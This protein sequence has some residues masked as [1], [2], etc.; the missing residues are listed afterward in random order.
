VD[1][2]SVIEG[3]RFALISKPALAEQIE[4]LL[5]NN[6]TIRIGSEYPITTSNNFGYAPEK[7]WTGKSEGMIDFYGPDNIQAVFGL[8][9]TGAEIERNSLIIIRDH[10]EAVQLVRLTLNVSREA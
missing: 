9:K 6:R 8:V 3:L 4:D 5:G 10:I 2:I 1:S 7:I